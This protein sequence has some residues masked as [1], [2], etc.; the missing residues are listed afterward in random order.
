[1][2]PKIYDYSKD[3]DFMSSEK[4]SEIMDDLNEFVIL[5]D[6]FGVDSEFEFIDRIVYE[7]KEY[8]FML[9]VDSGDEESSDAVIFLVE[10]INGGGKSYSPVVDP[11][12]DVLFEIFKERCKDRFDFE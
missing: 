1:M 3:G 8:L 2:V 7:N 10:S 12:V 9:P 11:L 5:T 6:E 4:K